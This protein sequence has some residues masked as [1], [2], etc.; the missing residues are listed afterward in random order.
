MLFVK[1]A[2]P[3]LAGLLLLLPLVL[4]AKCGVFK[5][6]LIREPAPGELETDDAVRLE[7]RIAPAIDAP[8]VAVR[9]GGVDLIGQLG[10]VPPFS[11]QGGSLLIGADLV[12][13]S[14]FDFD[15]GGPFP[16][17]SL[18][19]DGLSLGAH[20]FEVSGFRPSDSVTVV[21]ARQFVMVGPLD[22]KVRAT[23]AAGLLRPS[24]TQSG[25]R[26]GNAAAGDVSAGTPISYPD[27]SQLR[28]GVVEAIEARLAGGNPV[29]LHLEEAP[30]E[31][32]PPP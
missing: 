19:A 5:G 6:I 14:N 1:R 10:L 9:L 26:L 30:C 20:D 22:E 28:A 24:R 3:L 12:V 7:A 2:G 21:A 27:G 23:V 31:S 4:A 25:F 18:D 29:A 16:Q 11:G 8:S 17:L 15:P 32:D 13:V